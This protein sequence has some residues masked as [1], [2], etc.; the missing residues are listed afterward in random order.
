MEVSFI[1]H[2]FIYNGQLLDNKRELN[3]P[4]N[5]ETDF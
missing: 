5:N 1:L 4:L 2:V 3:A